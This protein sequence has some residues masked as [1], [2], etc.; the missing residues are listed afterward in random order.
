MRDSV[1]FVD[2]GFQ[3]SDVMDVDQQNWFAIPFRSLGS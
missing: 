1:A 3:S 2:E